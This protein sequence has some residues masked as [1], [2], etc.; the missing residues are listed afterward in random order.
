MMI[1]S[2]R[3]SGCFDYIDNLLASK[4][5]GGAFSVLD[6]QVQDLGFYGTGYAI[7]PKIYVESK[8]PIR[9]IF[10]ISDSR[11]PSFV[12]YYEDADFEKDD[13]TIKRLRNG[14]TGVLDWWEVDRRGE[15]SDIEKNVIAVAK[16]DYGIQNGITISL[17]NDCRGIAAISVISQ[18]KGDTYRRLVDEKFYMLSRY[19][20]IFHQHVM[21]H[22]KMQQHF[23]SGILDKVTE[24]EKDVLRHLVSGSS[25]KRIKD[26]NAA[27]SVTYGNKLIRIIKEKF[28]GITTN[29]LIYHAGLLMLLDDL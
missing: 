9:P 11:D 25:M 16:H 20:E 19:V 22:A 15:L 7:V 13:F 29:E 18:D 23:L 5:L 6:Q 26:T 2:S 28:G 14:E 24:K 1:G 21:Y 8:L 27:I 3:D 4:T 10:K 12:K 17:M